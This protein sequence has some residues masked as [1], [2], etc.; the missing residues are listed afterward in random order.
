MV[1]FRCNEDTVALVLL[2]EQW[3]LCVTSLCI[4]VVDLSMAASHS[5]LSP[6]VPALRVVKFTHSK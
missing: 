1:V 5:S 4:W 3:L 6:S 2:T